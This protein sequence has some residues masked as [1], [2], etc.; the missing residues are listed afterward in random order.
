MV[1][2]LD[3]IEPEKPDS[4]KT[5]KTAKAAKAK[6]K[7]WDGK[8]FR[9]YIE[10]K[11]AGKVVENLHGSQVQVQDIT[12]LQFED[13]DLE[14]QR[15]ALH[16]AIGWAYG[17]AN[18][19]LSDATKFRAYL[20][21]PTQRSFFWNSRAYPAMMSG[22]GAG[23]SLALTLKA[24]Q[25]CLDFPGT[26]VLLMRESYPQLMDTT[27]TTLFKIFNHFKWEEGVHFRHRISRKEI[28]IFVGR[29]QSTILY[30][31]AK[32]EG[33]TLQQAISDL[34]S[35]EIDWA[36]IDEATGIE[37]RI[38]MA[39]QGRVGRFGKVD[40]VDF[41][42]LAIVG[43][44]P[45]KS[46]WI[47]RRYVQQQEKDGSDVTNPQDYKLYH[48]STY[49]NKANLPLEY[50]KR[51]EAYPEW[52]KTAFLYGQFSFQPPEGQPVF[53]KTFKYDTYVRKDLKYHKEL[54]MIRGWDLSPTGVWK[55]CVICQLDPRGIL[56][57]LAEV[58]L[59][60]PGIEKF[61]QRVLENCSIYFPE[62]TKF[63]DYGDPA[64]FI[65]SQTDLMSSADILRKVG[66]GMLPGEGAIGVRLDAV[67][68]IMERMRDGQAGMLIDETR[69]T[70]LVQGFQGGYRHSVQEETHGRYSLTPVKDIFSHVQDALQ[71]ACSKLGIA[72]PETRKKLFDKL[73]E[74]KP[75][76]Y[77][78]R[79]RFK[80]KGFRGGRGKP[81]T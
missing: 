58:L 11:Y 35:L 17:L 7:T 39:L 61:G 79:S 16:P 55:A 21:R 31:P 63:L 26:R 27:I 51:L 12:D 76:M 62:A 37:E 57:V 5:V 36:G 71:Y 48:A 22:F 70:K 43:N 81:L 46:H 44:P 45:D 47:Y 69:C 56:L 73:K 72:A 66:V 32:N 30:R 6:R 77:K 33:Q 38:Y 60:E 15:L 40:K 34:Q 1:T 54:T 19:T 25:I 67:V 50:I 2:E 13:L 3:Y 42:Q 41:R 52:W 65:K 24:I 64:C 80:P 53:A 4:K 23:K 49:E 78:K 29:E 8:R 14:D 74:L 68:N 59:D 18:A 9:K 10:E 20:F 75:E 28:T